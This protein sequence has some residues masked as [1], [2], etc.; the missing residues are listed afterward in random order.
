MDSVG[1]RLSTSGAVTCF[2]CLVGVDRDGGLT[3]STGRS[4]P[5]RVS[6]PRLIPDVGT[7]G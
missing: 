6:K 7:L 5:T 1:V 3:P 4:S 2:P